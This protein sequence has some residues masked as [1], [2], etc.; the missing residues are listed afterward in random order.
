MQKTSARLK[1]TKK[2]TWLREQQP[3]FR[4][5]DTGENPEFDNMA[6]IIPVVVKAEPQWPL[7]VR[8]PPG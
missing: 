7:K 4:V 6:Y 3:V 1:H 5:G 2:I 8:E